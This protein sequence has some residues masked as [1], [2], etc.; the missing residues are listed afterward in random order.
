VP[1]DQSTAPQKA[2]EARGKHRNGENPFVAVL[3]PVLTV[4]GTGIGAIGFVIFFGGFIVWARFNAAGLPAN[5]AVARVPRSDLVATGASFLVPALLAA[6]GA[7]ALAVAGWDLAIG[8]RRRAQAREADEDRLSATRFI[9]GLEAELSQ[10]KREISRL[11]A[12]IEELKEEADQAAPQSPERAN[13]QL[14]RDEAEIELR[15]YKTC[16]HQLES[17]DIP[18]ARQAQ[19]AAAERKAEVKDQ[20]RLEQASQIILGAIPMVL[21][22]GIVIGLGLGGMKFW[23]GVLA[24]GVAVATVGMAIV[25]ASMT[26]HF[27]WYTL[28]VFLGVGVTIAAATFARTQSNVKISPIAALTGAAPV[29]GFYVAETSDSI[30][31]GVPEIPQLDADGDELTFDHSAATLV[32]VPKASVS[33]LTV[34]P[35]M[36]EDDAYR[37]SIQLALALC[38]HAKVA[39]GEV[40]KATASNDSSTLISAEP[41][42]PCTKGSEP[43]LERR[44]AA[45]KATS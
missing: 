12:R 23:Y 27:A 6:L 8:S 11:Q 37:R 31:F 45:A 1:D 34:G 26:R 9:A 28:C 13:A 41:L 4:I 14:E 21:A 19:L 32:R 33:G 10:T 7:V 36:G 25:V 39:A 18:T 30:Y 29:T 17:V 16:T 35:L 22:G 3:L 5:E 24:I 42:R 20:N 38:H 44:L 2:E 43:R 15:K 40:A